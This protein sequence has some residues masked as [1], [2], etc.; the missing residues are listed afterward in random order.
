[1]EAHSNDDQRLTNTQVNTHSGASPN[2]AGSF[3]IPTATVDALIDGK[4][5]A[6]EIAC[7]LCLA[8]FTDETGVFSTASTNAVYQR[9]RFG[10]NK[11]KKS[12]AGLCERQVSG[13]PLVSSRER[14][15]ADNGRTPPDGPVERAKVN[16]VLE[17]FG[18]A[19]EDRVWFGKGLVEGYQ[20]FE[21]PLRVLMDAGDVA[22]RLLLLLYRLHDLEEWVGVPPSSTLHCGF[23]PVKPTEGVGGGYSLIRFKRDGCLPSQKL[24]NRVF[25]ASRPPAERWA[26]FQAALQSLIALGLIYEAIV[27]VNRAPIREQGEEP[28]SYVY[29]L[30]TDAQPLYLL[31]TKNWYGY[32]TQREEGISGE[33]ASLAGE[34]RLPVSTFGGFFD[35]TYAAFSPPG[36]AVGITGTYRLRFRVAN[37]KNAF[38]RDAWTRLYAGEREALAHLQAIRRINRL[39]QTSKPVATS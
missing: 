34:L 9:T 17:T 22:A 3:C 21:D 10:W 12:M 4:A 26:E 11:V 37:G 7:C 19:V 30:P 35:G 8:A 39:V 13:L 38:V 33:T 32:K 27:V 24:V 23:I 18:Q 15:I 25:D 28:G 16:F 6:A 2:D 29:H 1:M 14:F 20:R 5:S 36:L 31:A